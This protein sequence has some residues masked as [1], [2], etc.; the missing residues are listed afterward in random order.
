MPVKQR[1]LL[2]WHY[3]HWQRRGATVAAPSPYRYSVA[4]LRIGE[5]PADPARRANKRDMAAVT[6][7][8]KGQ[9]IPGDLFSTHRP[10]VGLFRADRPT[11]GSVLHP[12]FTKS[13]TPGKVTHYLT[14]DPRIKWFREAGYSEEGGALTAGLYETRPR[15][16]RKG[17]YRQV[18]GAAVAGPELI[19]GEA[20]AQRAG[21]IMKVESPG[22]FT[23]PIP[24]HFGFS[25]NAR[26]SLTLSRGGTVIKRVPL[27]APDLTAPVPALAARYTLTASAR[28]N[29]P[30]TTLSTLVQATWTFKSG[31]VSRATPLPL[32]VLRYAPQGLDYLNRARAGTATRLP[33]WMERQPGSADDQART[34]K[35]QVSYDDGRTWRPLTTTATGKGWTAQV[36]NPAPGFVSLRAT[37]TDK[38]GNSV[39]QTIHRAYAISG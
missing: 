17:E 33:I 24:G 27:P 10:K 19:S 7:I 9:G 36:Q 5:L 13:R 26:G 16:W 39:T 1:G 2:Y 37:M 28:R 14:A 30:S 11:P 21:D 23:D 25:D 20:V 3:S 31:R 34:L 15:A 22:L 38:A 12:T 6:I 4:D 8:D 35:I 29:V 32:R 18:S